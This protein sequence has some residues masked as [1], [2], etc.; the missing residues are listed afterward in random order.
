MGELT[1]GIGMSHGP[2]VVC[3]APTWLRIG[4]LDHTSSLLVDT[5]GQPVSFEELARANGERYAEQATLEQL[6]YQCRQVKRSL[7]RL[8]DEIAGA[9]PD[10]VVVIGDDQ[11]ELFDHDNMPAL[12]VYYGEELIS[13]THT[14]RGRYGARVGGLDD[15]HK[16]YGM[17]EHRRWPG[18]QPLALHLITSLVERHFDVSAVKGITDPERGAIGHAFGVVEMQLMDEP[19]IPLVPVFV[20]TYWPPNQLPPARCYELG[21]ALREAIEA[22]PRDVRVALVASGGLS[23]FVT[24]EELDRRTLQALRTGDAEALCGLPLHLLNSGNSE[25]R[26]WIVV[27]AACRDMRLAWDDYIPVYRTAAGTGCGLT[28]ARWASAA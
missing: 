6:E 20:N 12:A 15:V 25:V 28:F 22:Y 18:H 19:K 16:G 21:V 26:N 4:E 13:C 5:T 14:R 9:G 23:H 10:V 17:D 27:A 1:I 3:E 7:A 2:M 8:K 11:F 24:D